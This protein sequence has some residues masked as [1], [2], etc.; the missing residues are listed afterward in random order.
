MNK[1]EWREVQVSVWQAEKQSNHNVYTVF[2]GLSTMHLISHSLFVSI[3]VGVKRCQRR[4]FA[5]WWGITNTCYHNH[6][7]SNLLHLTFFLYSIQVMVRATG[8]YRCRYLWTKILKLPKIHLTVLKDNFSCM[9]QLNIW[10]FFQVTI[11][12]SLVCK[13]RERCWISS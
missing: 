13:E 12:L 3:C 11:I 6:T 7:S 2:K 1:R 9:L 4:V 5:I 8:K 10:L